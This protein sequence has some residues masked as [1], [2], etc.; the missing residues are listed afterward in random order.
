MQ[1]LAQRLSLLAFKFDKPMRDVI[2]I[3]EIIELFSFAGTA[4]RENAQPGKFPI[5]SEPAATHDECVY[6]GS[7]HAWQFGERSAEFGSGHLK[8]LRFRRSHA[9]IG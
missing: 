5:A 4:R 3:Q 8:Y 2:F 6:D 7:A 9:G 1:P